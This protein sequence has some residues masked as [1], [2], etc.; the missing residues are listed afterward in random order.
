MVDT[1]ITGLRNGKLRLLLEKM[2]KTSRTSNLSCGIEGGLPLKCQ[3]SLYLSKLEEW[4][5][6]WKCT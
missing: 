3:G 4:I 5:G 2:E 1:N 6:S